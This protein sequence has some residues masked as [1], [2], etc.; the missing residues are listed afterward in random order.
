MLILFVRQLISWTVTPQLGPII[1]T[2]I[3]IFNDV[4]KFIF[5]WI[6]VLCGFASVGFITFQ[7]VPE[8]TTFLSSITYFYQ[9]SFAN[10]DLEIFDVYT[11]RGQNF[12]KQFGRWFVLLFVF[13]NA[14]ILINVVIAMMA[15]TYILMT[16]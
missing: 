7:P 9:A 13:V 4:G 2:I 6:I 5:I 14:L 3:V 1:S 8:L 10:Y 15:D 11:D 12:M 16:S